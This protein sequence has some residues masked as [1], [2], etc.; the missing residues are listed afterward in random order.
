M[1]SSSSRKW[2]GFGG[3]TAAQTLLLFEELWDVL[4]FKVPEVS[5]LYMRISAQ[6]YFLS[7]FWT[8][9]DEDDDDDDDS[10]A[11]AII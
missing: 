10:A 4:C 5:F 6:N 11:V 8:L 3:K 2:C 9:I 7:T 1:T